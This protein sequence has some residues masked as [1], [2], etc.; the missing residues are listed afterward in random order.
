MDDPPH[1]E[2]TE[3]QTVVAEL[4]RER[5]N[6]ADDEWLRKQL[7][8]LDE[9]RRARLSVV[10][11]EDGRV[12]VD[13]TSTTADSVSNAAGDEEWDP[14]FEGWAGRSK[15]EQSEADGG[16][17]RR[18]SWTFRGREETWEMDVPGPLCKYYTE[19]HRTRRFGA[20]IADPF[21][22]P[23]VAGLADRIRRFADR[24]GLS[25]RDRVNAAVRFVQSLEYTPDDVTTGQVE[26][27]K[28]PIETLVHE[29]GDCEDTSLLLGA[30]LRELGC[31]VAPVVLPNHHHMLL[32]VAP[33]FDVDGAYYGY[34]DTAYYTL[35]ATGHGWNIGDL[36][37]QYRNASAEVHPIDETPVLVHEW[38]ARPQRSGDVDLS[39]HVANFGD[40]PA[41]SLSV[42]LQFRDEQD[43]VCGRKQVVRDGTV[44]P[45]RSEQYT[46]TIGLPADRTIRGECVLGESGRV[47]DESTSAWHGPGKK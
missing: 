44:Q 21:D 6:R 31:E 36:P 1:S 28:Y 46:A 14:E 7:A 16:F 23:F 42:G 40:A 9:K 30:L 18:F 3:L 26:Y 41:E 13:P 43:R 12:D 25:R 10:V 11:D 4:L 38:H 33:D 35:E 19:R 39:V 22:E 8:K 47:H 27:P 29:G 20:Y 2:T 15:P 32:G 37:R 17:L 5:G 34:E 24:R 45:S